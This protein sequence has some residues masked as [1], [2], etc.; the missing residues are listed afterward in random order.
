M[1]WTFGRFALSQSAMAV[2]QFAL[3]ERSALIVGV[4]RKDRCASLTLAHVAARGVTAGKQL[5]LRGHA[6]ES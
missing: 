3:L 1:S 4:P 2:A 6:S 5:N